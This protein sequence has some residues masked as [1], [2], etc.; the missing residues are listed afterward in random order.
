[1]SEDIRSFSLQTG[2]HERAPLLHQLSPAGMR[3]MSI[4]QKL[5]KDKLRTTTNATCIKSGI[6]V[7]R[8]RSMDITTLAQQ[9]R[10]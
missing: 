3:C 8:E 5:P 9:E 4:V 10:A 7:R 6:S 1:M 2:Q